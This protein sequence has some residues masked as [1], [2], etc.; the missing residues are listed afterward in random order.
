MNS[1]L[2]VIVNLIILCLVSVPSN[3]LIETTEAQ[4]NGPSLKFKEY[5]ADN[6]DLNN[7]EF[8]DRVRVVYLLETTKE[9]EGANVELYAENEFLSVSQWEN[10]TVNKSE[11]V[12]KSID[13]DAWR[14]GEYHLWLKLYSASNGQMLANIDLGKF[15]LNMAMLE[16][17]LSITML[18]SLNI[19][20]GDD[21]RVATAFSDQVGL[22]YDVMGDVQLSGTP[23]LVQDDSGFFDCNDWPAGDYN[24]NLFYRNN[25]GYMLNSNLSFTIENRDAPEFTLNV[26]G[27]MDDMGTY[28]EV[29][30]KPVNKA[31]DLSNFKHEWSIVPERSIGNVSELDC[32]FWEPGVHR[33]VLTIT[34]DLNI[35][36][37]QGLN[38]VRL[39]PVN[40]GNSTFITNESEMKAW[41]TRSSGI[42]DS[43]Y[44]GYGITSIGLT[45]FFLLSVIILKKFGNRSAMEDDDFGGP[46]DADGLPTFVDDEG[47]LW[48][49]HPEGQVDWWDAKISDWVPFQ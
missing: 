1:K 22:R 35:R 42:V 26:T 2:F 13:I 31:D 5:R 37:T 3:M 8:V 7:D 19:E 43:G 28:C 48:R 44:M 6:L 21:C 24:L 25:L 36:A 32:T 40:D 30:A 4:A 47:H 11:P 12:T 39:P 41:P 45:I 38:L 9:S 33:I 27:N 29:V 14:E 10:T 16:P 18:N 20:T 17:Q 46:P 34:D 23:W 49:R 15:Y